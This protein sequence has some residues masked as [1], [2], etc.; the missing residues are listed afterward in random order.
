MPRHQTKN[1]T[2]II[3]SAIF[4]ALAVVLFFTFAGG[5]RVASVPPPPVIESESPPPAAPIL[6]EK[7]PEASEAPPHYLNQAGNLLTLTELLA[8]LEEDKL[9]TAIAASREQRAKMESPPL[10]QVVFPASV[11]PAVVPAPASSMS[12]PSAQPSKSELSSPQVL[13]IQGIDGKLTATVETA[14]GIKTLKVG[15][16]FGSGRVE[17]ISVTGVQIRDGEHTQIFATEE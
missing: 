17:G 1:R 4:L 7:A 9:L 8:E 10:P 5:R 6:E 11:P 15:D 14:S 3:F 12:A 2:I 16:S 13:S